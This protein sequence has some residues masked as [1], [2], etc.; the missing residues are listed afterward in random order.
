MGPGPPEIP[1][2]E[3]SGKW[4]SFQDVAEGKILARDD[5]IADAVL[6]ATIWTLLLELR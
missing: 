2:S 5:L 6:L 4:R 3:N 1:A